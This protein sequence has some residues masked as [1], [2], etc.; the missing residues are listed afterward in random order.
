MPNRRGK[1]CQEEVGRLKAPNLERIQ[2]KN[3]I[4]TQYGITIAATMIQ[5]RVLECA[6]IERARARGLFHSLRQPCCWRGQESVN[7]KAPTKAA[8]S[9]NQASD[10]RLPRRCDDNE[11][12]VIDFVSKHPLLMYT[13]AVFKDIEYIVLYA[14]QTERKLTM[15]I[16]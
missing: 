1:K 13:P 11:P 8:R 4:D 6:Q 2:E 16:I 9:R 12:R 5:A 15:G 7:Q 14:G 3:Y 10:A